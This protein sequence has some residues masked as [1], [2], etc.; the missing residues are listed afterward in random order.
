MFVCAQM[1]RVA[2]DV[3]LNVRKKIFVGGDAESGGSALPFDFECST[4]IDLG[5]GANRSVFCFDVAISSNANPAAPV[6][7]RDADGQQYNRD[8]FHGIDGGFLS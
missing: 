4:G 8:L 5:E 2:R 1:K 7:Q 3:T 6:G